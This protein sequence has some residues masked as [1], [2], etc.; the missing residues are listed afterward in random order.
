[1]VL[2]ST[3]VVVVVVLVATLRGGRRRGRVE[4]ATCLHEAN[5]LAERA[6]LAPQVHGAAALKLAAL[7]AHQHSFQF[8]TVC[9]QS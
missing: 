2:V 8:A 7:V 6:K 9:S 5:Q 1:M 3:I 4:L